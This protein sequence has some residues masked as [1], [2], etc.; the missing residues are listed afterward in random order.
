MYGERLK[1]KDAFAMTASLLKVKPAV[2]C[3]LQFL[4]NIVHK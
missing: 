4:V 3:P 1:E 2:S